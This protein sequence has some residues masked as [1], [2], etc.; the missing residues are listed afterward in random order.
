MDTGLARICIMHFREQ[1]VWE[2]CG[3]RRNIKAHGDELESLGSQA[4]FQPS[5]RDRS[6]GSSP[7]LWRGGKMEP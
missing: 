2:Q 4:P 1:S 5:S 3:P 7:T 6:L